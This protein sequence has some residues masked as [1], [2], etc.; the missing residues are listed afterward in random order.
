MFI[1]KKHI[2][3]RTVLQ[4]VGASIALP[5]VGA[6]LPAATAATTTPGGKVPKRF[7][8]IGFPHGAAEAGAGSDCRRLL[9]AR[10]PVYSHPL[11][12]LK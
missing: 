6:M 3:R 1:S 11:A 9:E 2:S 10:L 12:Q 8:F 7:A 4:G 5:L